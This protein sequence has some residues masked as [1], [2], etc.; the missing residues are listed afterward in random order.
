MRSGLV[1]EDERLWS[2]ILTR[3]LQSF[4]VKTTSVATTEEAIE[5]MTHGDYDIVLLDL[6]LGDDD[7][8]DVVTFVKSHPDIAAKTIVVTAYGQLALQMSGGLPIV[9]KSEMR[10][11]YPRLCEMLGE[12]QS[13]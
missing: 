7:P 13:G 1:I 12:R 5:E 8:Y 4:G 6:R 9:P 11:L 10:S 2:E 3:M